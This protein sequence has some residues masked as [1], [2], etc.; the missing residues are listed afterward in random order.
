MNPLGQAGDIPM[1]FVRGQHTFDTVPHN[2][3]GGYGTGADSDFHQLLYAVW[4]QSGA[5]GA[6][7]PPGPTDALVTSVEALNSVIN[8]TGPTDR[9]FNSYIAIG[10]NPF[11]ASNFAGPKG[12]DP[13]F[14]PFITLEA[15]V[16]TE[17]AYRV[18]DAVEVD[19]GNSGDYRAELLWPQG[20]DTIAFHHDDFFGGSNFGSW[21]PYYYFFKDD[22]V[23]LTY[24]VLS[25][26]ESFFGVF[27]TVRY[28]A[29][30]PVAGARPQSNLVHSV[31]APPFQDINDA[32]GITRDARTHFWR[33][34]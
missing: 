17:G 29:L 27:N 24:W 20:H 8:P 23:T 12:S 7:N 11:A 1:T 15:V 5:G 34:T 19:D 30:R 2:L 33:V 14:W 6:S 18:V 3:A 4:N 22:V 25:Q 13:D 26:P 21:P 32:N 9:F 31:P 16:H 10:G 28:A